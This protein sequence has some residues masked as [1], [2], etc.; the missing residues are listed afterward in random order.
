LVSNAA[1][2]QKMVRNG[3]IYKEHPYIEIIKKVAKLYENG[4]ANGMAG[5]YAAN[6]QLFGMTRYT[7]DSAV[8]VR[9]ALKGKSL[10]EAK[11]GWQ[12]VIDGWENIKMTPEGAPDGLQ[13]ADA[14]FTVQSWWQ[15]TMVNKTTKKTA[16]I[17]MVLFDMFNKQGKIVTQLEYYDPAPMLAAMQ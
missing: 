15:L 17:E 10:A 11:A 4:D 13:Y 7:P 1:L 2:A 9:H 3:T 6:A 8:R 16:T 14:P 12:H 5:Y